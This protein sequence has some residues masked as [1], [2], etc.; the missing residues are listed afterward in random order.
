MELSYEEAMVFAI[1]GCPNYCLSVNRIA[2]VAG[3][4]V[5]RETKKLIC[6]L[7]D[8]LLTKCEAEEYPALYEYAMELFKGKNKRELIR[9]RVREPRCSVREA[10]AVAEARGWK[11]INGRME[12]E[13]KAGS[14]SFVSYRKPRSIS[15]AQR[16][17][18]RER[19]RQTGK[20]GG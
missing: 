9:E 13:H 2:M 14:K 17:A 7:H 20:K 18:A 19:M 5:E 8:R 11:V 3:L 10:L 1:W 12:R 6:T 15:E 4:T 16:Q